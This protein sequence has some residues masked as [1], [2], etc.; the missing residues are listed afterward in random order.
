MFI[1][2]LFLRSCSLST[3][4]TNMKSITFKYTLF[5]RYEWHFGL[6]NLH[7]I[8]NLL[9]Y[10][11]LQR[12][13]GWKNRNQSRRVWLRT[14]SKLTHGISLSLSFSLFALFAFPLCGCLNIRPVPGFIFAL[15]GNDFPVLIL[16]T[17]IISSFFIL[18]KLIERNFVLFAF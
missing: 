11:T 5:V 13:C 3:K 14:V 8:F 9:M 2:F 10:V 16:H 6:L 15:W 4:E 12:V 18:W 17:H 7:F 1:A